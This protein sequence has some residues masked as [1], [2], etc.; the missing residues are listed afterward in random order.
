MANK[1][2][3]IKNSNHLKFSKSILLTLLLSITACSD[4]SN[5]ISYKTEDIQALAQTVKTE[6][7]VM[8]NA[9][10]CMYCNQAKSWLKQNNFPFTDCDMY[11]S[12]QCEQ[13]YNEYNGNGIPFIV[14]NR[15]GKQHFM[16][17]GFDTDELI[18]ALQAKN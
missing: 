1:L 4:S 16:R 3:H 10:D 7:I 13:E 2:K 15:H 17:D 14:I 11:A 6:E 9:P 18:L 12:K 5:K 8:Y